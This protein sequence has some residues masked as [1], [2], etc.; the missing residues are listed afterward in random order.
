[1]P[2]KQRAPV[3]RPRRPP[4]AESKFG[5]KSFAQNPAI[6]HAVERHATGKTEIFQ[7]GLLSHMPGHAE[8][9][10]LGHVLD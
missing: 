7:P 9:D 5:R 6:G 4:P 2:G 10:L 1:M 3:R 8:H